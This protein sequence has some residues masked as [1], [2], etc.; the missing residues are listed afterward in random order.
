MSLSKENKI[1][2]V[3]ALAIATRMQRLADAFRKD[4]E[5]IYRLFDIDFQ[6]KWFPVIVSLKDGTPMTITALADEIGYAHPST[7]ALLKELEKNKI[8]VS[9]KDK[10]DERK[11]LISLSKYGLALVGKM[12]PIWTLMTEATEAIIDTEN[13]L[14]KAIEEVELKLQRQSFFQKALQLK[15][16]TEN[17]S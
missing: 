16:A 2:Q 1:D 14:L 15:S 8:I 6:P 13:N 3:G 10:T 5:Q 12:Q 4:G 17:Q 9:K 7:I 11:R